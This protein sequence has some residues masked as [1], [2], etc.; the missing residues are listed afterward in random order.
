MGPKMPS[1]AKRELDL[2]DSVPWSETITSYDK[3]HFVIYLRLLDADAEGAQW[4]EVAT[5]VLNRNPLTEPERARRCWETHLE[6]ARWML[7]KGYRELL[8]Q[9]AIQDHPEG[10]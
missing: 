4:S 8:V 10:D 6:R 7:A 5:I 1:K 2:A 9:A 3:A